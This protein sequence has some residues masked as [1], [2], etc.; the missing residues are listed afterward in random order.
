MPFDANAGAVGNRPVFVGAFV[1]AFHEATFG[2]NFQ[3]LDAGLIAN[4]CRR[5]VHKWST[6]GEPCFRLIWVLY[7]NQLSFSLM[8][9][10]RNVGQPGLEPGTNGL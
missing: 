4:C 3:R 9:P 6:D 1:D 10:K 2:F 7:R 8:N 5:V